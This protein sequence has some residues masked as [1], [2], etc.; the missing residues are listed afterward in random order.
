MS[1]FFLLVF[2]FFFVSCVAKHKPAS[3]PS[4]IP[5]DIDLP[6]D[7]ELDD[8]DLPEAGEDDTGEG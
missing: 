4:W 1:R 3:E 5:R 8:D 2:C 7:E 6:D